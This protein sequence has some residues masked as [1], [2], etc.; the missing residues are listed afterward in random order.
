MHVVILFLIGFLFNVS[1]QINEPLPPPVEITMNAS[2]DADDITIMIEITPL[3]DM[4][5]DLSCMLPLGVE[6][7]ISSEINLR[8]IEPSAI[9]IKERI[10][11]NY[12]N[13][14]VLYVGFLPANKTATYQFKV[15]VSD[16]KEYKLIAITQAL[17]KWGAKQE[18]MQIGIR[19]E[20]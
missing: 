15:K 2:V 17:S 3:E 4:H 8:S 13:S 6:P 18:T 9:S 14:I 20:N 19:N 12:R 11:N 5:L 1:A 10:E 16:N 7:V